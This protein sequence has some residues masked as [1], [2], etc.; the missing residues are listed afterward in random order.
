MSLAHFGKVLV[1]A[2]HPDD[3]I[4]GCGGTMARL[5]QE[6]HEVEVCLVTRGRPPAFDEEGVARVMAEMEQAHAHLGVSRVHRLDFPAARLD[7]VPAWQINRAIGE[8]VE[9]V[10]PDTLFLPFVGDIHLDHQI[11]FLGAMVAARPRNAGVPKRILCYETLSETNWL[12]APVTPAFV[13]NCY[14][15]IGATLQRKLDAFALFESQLK[16]FPDERSLKTIESLAVVRGST[17][18]AQAA[19]AFVV[20]RQIEGRL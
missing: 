3:E 18:F 17:V 16:P 19:E 5:V 12:A 15:D 8:V 2:P 13:P 20:V 7:T 11:A 6:G 1:V 9:E 14:I 4:L 10:A